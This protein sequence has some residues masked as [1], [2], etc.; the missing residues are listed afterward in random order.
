MK[1]E[2][3]LKET[4]EPIIYMDYINTYQKGDFY[5]IRMRDIVIKYPID[6]IW[7][8]IETYKEEGK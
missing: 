6:N 7:R 1:V 3:W 4:S 2:V 8:I 5:C